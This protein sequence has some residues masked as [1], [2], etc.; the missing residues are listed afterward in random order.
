M[1]ET[2]GSRNP[3][4]AAIVSIGS[5]HL[6]RLLRTDK[7][8]RLVPARGGRNKGQQ[9]RDPHAPENSAVETDHADARVDRKC[10]KVCSCTRAFVRK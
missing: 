7:G 6:I 2:K 3:R 1:G 9:R 5:R 10:R 4:A 8:V